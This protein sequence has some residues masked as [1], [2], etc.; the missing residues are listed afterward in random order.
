MTAE[1]E[2][3]R[4]YRSLAVAQERGVDL[5]DTLLALSRDLR[6]ARRDEAVTRAAGRRVAAVIPIVVVL[7]PIVLLFTAAPLP[8]LIFGGATP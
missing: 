8:T 3:A 1:P 5:A 4:F 6:V 7:A 2:A